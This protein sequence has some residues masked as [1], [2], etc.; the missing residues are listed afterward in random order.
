MWPP[1]LMLDP[2][3][4]ESALEYRFNRM[5]HA[6]SKAIEAGT[7]NHAS[8]G[9]QGQL[10]L[11]SDALMFPWE[12]CLT[13]TE[14]QNSN[15]KIG[16]WGEYEQHISGD[17][18]LAARQYFYASG[19]KDWLSSRGFPL[20]K[21][22]AD[23]YAKRAVVSN[24]SGRYDSEFG[25]WRGRDRSGEIVPEK[26][27]H[28]SILAHAAPRLPCSLPPPTPLVNLVMGPDEYAWPVNNSAYTN[29]VAAIA[30]DFA[31]EAA[32]V[33]W[34][35]ADP[36]WSTVASGLKNLL[37]NETVPNRPDLQGGYHPEYAGFPK[38]PSNPK[39]K[40]ADTVMLSF[41]LG[42]DMDPK[43]LSNDLDFYDDVTDPNGP[44]MTWAIFAIGW[45]NVGNFTR[46]QPHFTRQLDNIKG[47][48]RVW[49]ETPN[50][51]TTNF[52][53]GAGGFIQSVLFGTSG[54][55]IK[56]DGLYFTPPPPNASGWVG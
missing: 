45:I 4:A 21:G 56:Q 18:A 34:Q 19:D 40:Q 11:S 30:L 5:D 33:L 51:G 3:S 22:I 42:V 31:T 13:G 36:L 28:A 16:P 39:V 43:V 27:S 38:D 2:P 14:V 24:V 53:T 17:I 23:F 50:G 46:S 52:I 29:A 41:P 49:Q 47:P 48:F 54:M 44:A 55:R 26:S 35:Q 12:S 1:L 8:S 10:S 32:G 25:G 6:H 9:G 37:V 15:G 20:V 7:D